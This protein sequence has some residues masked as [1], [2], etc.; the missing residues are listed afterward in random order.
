MIEKLLTTDDA[1]KLSREEIYELHKKH[2]NSTFIDLLQQL[3]FDKKVVSADGLLLRY[4]DGSEALD[5]ISGFGSV[6]FGHENNPN[7][8]HPHPNAMAAALA[9]DL[10]QITP[11]KINK[12]FFFNDGARPNESA[13]KIARAY[14]GRKKILFA[15]NAFHGRSLGTLSASSNKEYKDL[16]EPLVPGFESIPYNN[17]NA[18]EEKLKTKEFAALILEPIQGEAG[19]II[20]GI[21]YIRSAEFLCKKYKTLFILD[22]VQTGFGR[23]G[24]MFAAEHDDTSPDIITMAKALGGG[25]AIIGAMGV[26]DEVYSAYA[27]KTRCLLDNSTFGGNY[28]SCETAIDSINRIVNENLVENARENGKYILEKLKPLKEKHKI[29]KDVRGEGL[30]IGVEFEKPA[31]GGLKN[32]LLSGIERISGNMIDR[33]DVS[34][35]FAG[36]MLNEHGILIAFSLNNHYVAR[37]EPPLIVT[38]E[39]IDKAVDAF[40]KVLEKYPSYSSLLNVTMK[41]YIGRKI[42]R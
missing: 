23:T 19:V 30:L 8:L 25:L 24:K 14:T 6:P 9:Y 7:I 12:F 36:R 16:F 35:L 15:E 18:L 33:E 20:P 32:L 29:I 31:E 26:T 22:E 37:F 17:I 38:K 41:E 34:A 28:R 39:Q 27:K 21:G 40:D 2:G 1:R 4:D 11:G 13:F 3:G 10:V 42:K 5:F